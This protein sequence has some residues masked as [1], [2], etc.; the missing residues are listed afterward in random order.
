M[1]KVVERKYQ[2]SKNKM[3]QVFSA[4]DMCY[5]FSIDTN[6]IDSWLSSIFQR[7]ETKKK[8]LNF[9]GK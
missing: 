5:I 7:T 2:N 8:S 1:R 3:S 6:K 4:H 9:K